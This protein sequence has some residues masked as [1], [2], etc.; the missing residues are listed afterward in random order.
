MDGRSDILS[1]ITW[2][3]E[4]GALVKIKKYDFG[5]NLYYHHGIIIGEKEVSQLEMFPFV[6]VYTFETSEI[7]RQF[8][9]SLEIISRPTGEY[10]KEDMD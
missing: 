1:S 10:N 5:G 2:D 6:E 8:P 7:A 9:D 3:V 4:S